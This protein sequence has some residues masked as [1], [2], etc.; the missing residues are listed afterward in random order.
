PPN[1]CRFS[2]ESAATCVHLVVRSIHS[3]FGS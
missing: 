2:N 3:P 1:C